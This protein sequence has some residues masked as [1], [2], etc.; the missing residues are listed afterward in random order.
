MLAEF[1]PTFLQIGPDII[2]YPVNETFS[3]QDFQVRD[4]DRARCRM[5]GVG[6]TVVK[7]AALV[8]QNIADTIADQH[9]TERQVA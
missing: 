6:K 3:L 5:S 9:P 4:R 2:P 7:L 1:C 8:D